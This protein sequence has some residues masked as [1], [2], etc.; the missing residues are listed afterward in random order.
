M[1]SKPAAPARPAKPAYKLQGSRKRRRHCTG[2][3]L[4]A[5]LGALLAAGAAAAFHARPQLWD[6]LKEAAG[7][8]RTRRWAKLAEQ[9]AAADVTTTKKA[10][11]APSVATRLFERAALPLVRDYI[12]S[13]YDDFAASKL[14]FRDLKEHLGS[15]MGMTYEELKSDELSAVIEDA[16]DAI[17]TKCDSGK[18]DR[19]QCASM[20]GYVPTGEA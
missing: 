3:R 1:P 14:T 17:S 13:H 8:R 16:V 10:E 11:A 19:E 6:T 5:L 7:L 18:T 2:L 15:A 12:I 9:Q 4:L 20:L